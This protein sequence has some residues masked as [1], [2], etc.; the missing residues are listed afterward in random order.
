MKKEPILVILLASILFVGSL[1]ISKAFSPVE[2]ADQILSL[3]TLSPVEPEEKTGQWS[4]CENIVAPDA[5]YA[6]EILKDATPIFSEDGQSFKVEW[7]LKNTGTTPLI[8]A[9]AQCENGFSFSFGTQ[10]EQDRESRFGIPTMALSGWFSPNRVDMTEWKA[11]PGETFHVAFESRLP[12][13]PSPNV[14]REFFQP[15]VEGKGWLNEAIYTDIVM[16]TPTD[17]MKNN[18]RFVKSYSVAASDLEGQEKNIV[19]DRRSQRMTALFGETK[20]WT[21]KV[22]TGASATPTPRG[23]YRVRSK[24]ELRRG[25]TA[26]YYRMPYFQQLSED[27]IGI[28][29]LPYLGSKKG[30]DFWEEAANHL[31]IPVSHGCIRASE[32]DAKLLFE[33]TDKGTAV[34]IN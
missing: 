3:D 7:T 32:E 26:P 6:A 9:K 12:E 18:L 30:G 1:L 31:G 10:G 17:T 25:Y 33:F 34:R 16:G 27:G 15:V 20:I 19:V 23:F 5:I 2:A 13:G 14:Y 11:D 8:S 29:A 24:D 28:H 22:S 4:F 21:M